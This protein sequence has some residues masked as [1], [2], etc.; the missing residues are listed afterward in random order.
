MRILLRENGEQ[1]R[2]MQV[3]SPPKV[4]DNIANWRVVSIDLEETLSKGLNDE[5]LTSEVIIVNVEKL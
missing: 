1:V 4:G 5:E 2:A 3:T